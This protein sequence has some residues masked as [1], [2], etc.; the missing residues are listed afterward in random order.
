[1]AERPIKK[2]EDILK[3]M[4]PFGFLTTVP[5]TRLNEAV[6]NIWTYLNAIMTSPTKTRPS[7]YWDYHG[8]Y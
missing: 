1:M 8:E 2:K 6:D 4:R 7:E 3:A 5:P